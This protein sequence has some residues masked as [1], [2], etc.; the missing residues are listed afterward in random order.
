MSRVVRRAQIAVD[1]WTAEDLRV[2]RLNERSVEEA[3]AR[4]Q[5]IRGRAAKPLRWF[6]DDLIRAEANAERRK[7]LVERFGEARLLREG[8]ASLLDRE[9]RDAEGS[10]PV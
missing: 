2:P 4:H 8:G 7:C 3:M 9:G 10:G 6:A 5:A 1:R